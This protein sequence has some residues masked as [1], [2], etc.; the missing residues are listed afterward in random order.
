MTV[1]KSVDKAYAIKGDNLHYTSIITNT[2]T[3]SKENL[4]ATAEGTG[5]H[6]WNKYRLTGLI[7]NGSNRV[8]IGCY[9]VSYHNVEELL[10]LKHAVEFYF[11]GDIFTAY[12]IAYKYAG[13]Q[14]RYRHK[15]GVAQPLHCR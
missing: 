13:K 12:Y 2:G 8:A 9:N 4:T 14:S 15:H 11:V 10:E 5:R 7:D 1:V 3:N 6:F